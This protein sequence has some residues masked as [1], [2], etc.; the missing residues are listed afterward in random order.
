MG[1][2]GRPAGVTLYEPN[3]A[4]LG[5][6]LVAPNAGDFTYLIDMDGSD[7]YTDGVVP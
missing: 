7:S 5:Y 3:R 1:W 4:F 6:T 2:A